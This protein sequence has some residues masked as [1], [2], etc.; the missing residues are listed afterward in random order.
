MA[1]FLFD[2]EQFNLM[3]VS[4]LLLITV[5]ILTVPASALTLNGHIEMIKRI[6]IFLGYES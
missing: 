5:V 6:D 2:V 1:K 4:I 3:R